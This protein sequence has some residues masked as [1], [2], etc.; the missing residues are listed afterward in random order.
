MFTQFESVEQA[1]STRLSDWG[2]DEAAEEVSESDEGD[3]AGAAPKG[4]PEKQGPRLMEDKAWEHDGRLFDLA[5]QPRA[6]LGDQLFEDHNLFRDQVFA[7]LKDAEYRVSAPKLKLLL[8]AVSW[9]VETAAPVIAKAHKSGKAK[10]SV[11]ANPFHGLF[12]AT[13]TATRCSRIRTHPDRRDTEQVPRLE[14]G[15]I[16]AF[17]RREVLPYTPDAWVK[18]DATRIGFKVSFTRQFYK[19]Q[20]L[21]TLEEIRAHVLAAEREAEG[22]L[23]GLLNIAK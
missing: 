7:W 21:R 22:L 17:V 1:L 2:S 10:G 11:R 3:G 16:E 20:A 6:A 15:G 19:P 12:E 4:L 13:V 14:E 18:A 9:R 5:N 8:K 23:N